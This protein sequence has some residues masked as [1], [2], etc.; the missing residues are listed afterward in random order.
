MKVKK[1]SEHNSRTPTQKVDNLAE[2][3]LLG[4]PLLSWVVFQKSRVVPKSEPSD[5]P[6]VGDDDDGDDDSSDDSDDLDG[7][8][9]SET[10]DEDGEDEEP[11]N[12]EDDVTD[13]EAVSITFLKSDW[14]FS[15][16]ILVYC[17]SLSVRKFE[18]LKKEGG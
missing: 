6:P 12:S 11:L 18:D 13:D 7:K 10:Q 3:C 1:N 4:D 14:L 9:K 2:N 17:F 15:S 16:P 8:L 5:A